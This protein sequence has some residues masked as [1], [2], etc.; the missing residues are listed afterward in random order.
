V[1]VVEPRLERETG[2]CGDRR[3]ALVPGVAPDLD[4]FDA[5]IAA[6]TSAPSPGR[7]V[8]MSSRSDS[9]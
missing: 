9:D 4:P 7:G 6:W 2:T 8:R 5:A 1:V 3:A